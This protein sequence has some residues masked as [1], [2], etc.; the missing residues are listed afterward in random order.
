MNYYKCFS[1]CPTYT[2]E[3]EALLV[4]QMRGGNIEARN[5]LILSCVPLSIKLARSKSFFN[6][7]IPVDD[8]I[9]VAIG[10]ALPYLVT[11]LNPSKGRLTT[12][13]SKYLPYHLV[14]Y[15]NR[16]GQQITLPGK[17]RENNKDI[18]EIRNKLKKQNI[19]SVLYTPKENTTCDVQSINKAAKQLNISQK[20]MDIT[21]K[22]MRGLTVLE[23]AKEYNLSK[24]RVSQIEHETISKLKI[25]LGV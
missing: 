12:F 1:H 21:H 14:R 7:G 19:G 13:I 22:R 9:S 15:I 18:D 24:Q 6:R 16:Y 3:E 8:L 11:K 2:K 17:T 20:N 4:K 23:I 5:N 10:E 25:Q